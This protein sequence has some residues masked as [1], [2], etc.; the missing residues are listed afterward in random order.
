MGA[1]APSVRVRNSKRAN[2]PA[3][4]APVRAHGPQYSLRVFDVEDEPEVAISSLQIV[5]NVRE[6][7]PGF[8]L[9]TQRREDGLV[10][11]A[12]Q[13]L[14]LLQCGGFDVLFDDIQEVGPEIVA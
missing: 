10:H 5:E 3:D 7:D 1:I 6:R 9:A 11:Q 13:Q 12:F 4:A 2:A 14:A 8:L